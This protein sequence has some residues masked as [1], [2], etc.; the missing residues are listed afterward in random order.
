MN[1]FISY[2][3]ED[4]SAAICIHKCLRNQDGLYP[5]LDHYDLLPGMRWEEEI[6]NAIQE[7][8]IVLILLSKHSVNKTGFVQKEIRESIDR[9]MRYPPDKVFIVPVRLD[10]CKPKFRE[11]RELHFVD[12]FPDWQEGIKRLHMALQKIRQKAEPGIIS[13]MLEFISNNQSR[14]TYD[15]RIAFVKV[16][17]KCRKFDGCNLMHLDL[18]KLDLSHVDFTGANLVG[19]NLSR[20]NLANVKFDWANLERANLKKSSLRATRF[21]KANLWGVSFKR[22]K[23]LRQS[24]VRDNNIFSV[25]G[26]SPCQTE[27]FTDAGGYFAQNYD[28]L[29]QYMNSQFFLSPESIVTN[30]PWTKDNYFRM[31]LSQE[32]RS[33]YERLSTLHKEFGVSIADISEGVSSTVA[34]SSWRAGILAIDMI[35]MPGLRTGKKLVE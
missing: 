3:R 34:S 7:S 4:M 33:I 1:V 27:R 15:S 2:A 29:F 28:E 25:S 8:Q 23:Y 16:L 24:I 20:A 12:L 26:L 19:C 18:S 9:A 17:K 13:D 31:L 6:M 35:D 10:Q 11:L 22:A 21:V 30:C 32:A 5:W 14:R